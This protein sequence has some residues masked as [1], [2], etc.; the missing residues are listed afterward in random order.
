[1][2]RGFDFWVFG[3]VF[4]WFG[5]GEMVEKHGLWVACFLGQLSLFAVARRAM[6]WWMAPC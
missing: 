2:L 6:G 4:W 5:G 3:V 1:M